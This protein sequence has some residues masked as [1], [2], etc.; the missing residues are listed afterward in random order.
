M[1]NHA[2][3]LSRVGSSETFKL[4]LWRQFIY[5]KHGQDI[6]PFVSAIRSSRDIRELGWDTTP[7]FKRLL[8]LSERQ[9]CVH[10]VC[11]DSPAHGKDQ[12][13]S[14]GLM[15]YAVGVYQCWLGDRERFPI[16]HHGRHCHRPALISWAVAFLQLSCCCEHLRFF[17]WGASSVG[18]LMSLEALSQW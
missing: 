1:P 7:A 18:E 9:M 14:S 2:T 12:G 3:P 5:Y 4:P 8:V 11:N 10:T 15:G 16:S 17:T 6:F 13:T